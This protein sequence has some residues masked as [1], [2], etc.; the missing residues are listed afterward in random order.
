MGSFRAFV[1]ALRGEE[2]S[3]VAGLSNA[4]H[5]TA[6]VITIDENDYIPAHDIELT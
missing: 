5:S 4:S 3:S 6:D 2:K 1:T